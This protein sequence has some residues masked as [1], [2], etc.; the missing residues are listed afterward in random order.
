MGQRAT[1]LIDSPN[2]ELKR[3][4][5][6]QWASYTP[7]TLANALKTVQDEGKD[8]RTALVVILTKATEYMHISCLNPV[9]HETDNDG[10]ST[11]HLP[12]N[13]VIKGSDE[14][15]HESGI[16]FTPEGQA[17]AFFKSNPYNMHLDSHSIGV[18]YKTNEPDNV[19]FFTRNPKTDD[20]E[21][22][23][24][25]ISELIQLSDT[26]IEHV[27]SLFTTTQPSN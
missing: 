11:E 19:T 21:T 1:I 24:V 2:P 25:T 15:D 7:L 10:M 4:T 22:F 18:H 3:A 16:D 9:K 6:V 5:T 17:A 23:T 12:G 27:Y 20:I 13:I 14:Y 26:S 8:P